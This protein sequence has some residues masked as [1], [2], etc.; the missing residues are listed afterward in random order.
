MTIEKP[1]RTTEE[2][3]AFGG[4]DR[5]RGILT[6]PSPCDGK[7]SAVIVA[8][9]FGGEG[10]HQRKFFEVSHALAENGIACLRFDFS[11]CGDSKG[12]YNDVNISKWFSDFS[13]AYEFLRVKRDIDTNRIGFLAYSLGAVIACLFATNSRMVIPAKAL[14]LVAPALDQKGLMKLWHTPAEMKKWQRQGFLNTPKGGLGAQ[15]QLDAERDFSYLGLST[16]IPTLVI[17]G[18]K[19]KDVPARFTKKVFNT[20]LSEKKLL[21]TVKEADHG[22][23]SYPVKE[24]LIAHSLDW[25]RKYL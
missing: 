5:L 9:G 21:V 3:V 25:F 16:S 24:Q 15:Y 18:G 7:V 14:V 23:E 20:V 4:Q 13:L 8:H 6:L 19:D 17:C 2:F 10:C 11:G 1:T 12:D 22:F